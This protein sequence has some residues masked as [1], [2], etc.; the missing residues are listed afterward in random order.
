MFKIRKMLNSK[1]NGAQL[2]GDG[3]DS[4]GLVLDQVGGAGASFTGPCAI[5]LGDATGAAATTTHMG[6]MGF[7]VNMG[8]R[9]IPALALLGVRDGSFAKRVYIRNFTKTAFRTNMAGDNVGVATG[10]MCEGVAIESVIAFPQNGVTTDIFLLDGIF[11]STLKQCKA[12]GYTLAENNAVGFAIGKNSEARRVKLDACGGANMV[13]FG[14]PSNYNLVIAYGQWARD[15]WD[16]DTTL[17]NVEGGGVEFHGGTASGQLLPLNCRSFNPSPY[18]SANAAV[19][20]PLYKFRAA[21][22]CHAIGINHFSTVKASVQVTA[23]N[24]FNNYA[25]LDINAEPSAIAGTVVVFDVGALVSNLVKIRASG[26]ALRK[27]LTLTPDQQWYDIFPNGAYLQTDDSWTS[28]N[29]GPPNKVRVRNAALEDLIQFDGVNNRIRPIKPFQAIGGEVITTQAVT[30]GGGTAAYTPT[31]TNADYHKV[32][33][34]NAT[35]LTVNLPASLIESGKLILKVINGNGATAITPAFNAGY[36]G[37]PADAIPAG[38]SALYE[39]RAASASTLAL[40]G[41]AINV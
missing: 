17:E 25:E 7:S 33:V 32:T 19:L 36:K 12:F 38:Q 15:C 2:Y 5:Q 40:L 9:D 26:V 18:F 3:I 4:A 16:Y 11:E 41:Y 8:G 30:G 20:N 31:M 37:A 34:T 21:N 28:I 29:A 22:A 35:G 27:E 6:A 1:V 14:N 24:G 13:K 10:K 39:F 23:E